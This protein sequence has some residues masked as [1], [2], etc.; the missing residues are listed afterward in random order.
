M[1]CDLLLPPDRKRSAP[2]FVFASFEFS[3]DF[4]KLPNKLHFTENVDGVVY[5]S[6]SGCV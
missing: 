4:M 5:L 2:W 1:A 3:V 6:L